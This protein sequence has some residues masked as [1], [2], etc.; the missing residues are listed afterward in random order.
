MAS[1]EQKPDGRAVT[2]APKP[3]A[4]IHYWTHDD[5]EPNYP[6]VSVS[7]CSCGAIRRAWQGDD[8]ENHEE[9]TFLEGW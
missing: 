3:E 7:T 1:D 6:P 9:V 4:H 8:G 2:T 5:V